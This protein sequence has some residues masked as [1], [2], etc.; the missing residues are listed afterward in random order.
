MVFIRKIRSMTRDNRSKTMGRIY[1]D[2]DRPLDTHITYIDDDILYADD[3]RE[4]RDHGYVKIPT[5]VVVVCVNGSVQVSLNGRTFGVDKGGVMICPSQAIAGRTSATD[6]LECKLLCLTDRAIQSMLRQYVDVWNRALYV[7]KIKVVT[8]DA[9]DMDLLLRM[10]EM[11]T[12]CTAGDD[13]DD[14]VRE[15]VRSMIRVLLIG[16]CRKLSGAPGGDEPVRRS[17]TGTTFHKFLDLLKTESRS[18]HTV[19]YY[20]ERLFITPKYLSMI[21][22]KH[23]GKTAKEWINDYLVEQAH[24]YL[25]STDMPIKEI[26]DRLGF[27]TSS[28]FGRYVKD[29]FGLSPMAYRS[30]GR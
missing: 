21:C 17:Q 24:Y 11:I 15:M 12:L 23:S 22:V 8:L 18:R 26:S 30:A 25:R 27:P 3:I 2:I 4:A 20:S 28:S 16:L 10:H 6:D 7:Q 13:A 1:G 29:H 19:V 5:N 14:Y 9:R